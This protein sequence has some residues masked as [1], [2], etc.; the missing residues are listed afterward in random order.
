MAFDQET[1]FWM[2]H[3]VPHFPDY[4]K[5]GYGYPRT[6]HKYG[7][8]FL[9]MTLNSS[10]INDVGLQLRY[11]NPHVHD[12]FMPKEWSEVFPNVDA[13]LKG[14]HTFIL[15]YKFSATKA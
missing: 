2:V 4:V 11:N 1:G 7:Q 14:I 12:G 5:N 8:M 10:V 15:V 9:C 13:L 6:G 3:S